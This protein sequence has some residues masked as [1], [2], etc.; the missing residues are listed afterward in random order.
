MKLR[1]AGEAQESD[2]EI[3]ARTAS[4]ITARIDGQE[5][6]ARFES[7]ADGGLVRLAGRTARVLAVRHRDSILVAVGPA[8]FEF[9][10]GAAAGRRRGR[11]L[12]AHEIVAP[13]PGKVLKILVAEGDQVA[14][15][16]ALIVLEAMKMET[17]LAAESAAVIGKIRVA[18]GAMV[19]HG[20]VLIELTPPV[21]PSA[22]ESV[23]PAR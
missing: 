6:E 1:L 2:V 19:D 15:G 12:A 11:G 14:S 13:M 16:A 8:H 4:S 9:T 22:P 7:T 23:P 5:L 10:A 3:L 20:A 18:A 17:T 21:N